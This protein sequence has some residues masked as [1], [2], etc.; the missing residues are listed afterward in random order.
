[1]G[2]RELVSTRLNA[3][4]C[5]RKWSRRSGLNG[6]PADYESAALPTELRRPWRGTRRSGRQERAILADRGTH[7]QI[8]PS[9]PAG[10]GRARHHRTVARAVQDGG[11]RERDRH[12]LRRRIHG[13]H[14]DD[15]VRAGRHCRLQ[16][17]ARTA[18][19][20]RWTTIGI[21]CGGATTTAPATS[22]PR[23]SVR[24]S[25]CRSSTAR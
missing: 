7:P 5:G 21:I 2:V 15:R 3:R 4:F 22:A 17:A 16:R 11:L 25:R 1:M 18:R 13:R 14:H 12:G 6:R 10:R 9:A 20:G 24:P 23:C 8:R 19:A